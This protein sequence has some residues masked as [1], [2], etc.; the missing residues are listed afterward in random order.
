MSKIVKRLQKPTEAIDRV[1]LYTV[2]DAV[3]LATENANAKFDETLEIAL[4]LGV[5]PRHADQVVRGMTELPHGTGKSM[6]V[7][8]FARDDKAEEAK[9]E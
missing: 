9:A 2:A 8:V 3:K 6:R 5:D 4:N 1:K 7:A